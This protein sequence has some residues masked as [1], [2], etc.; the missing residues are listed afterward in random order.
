MCIKIEKNYLSLNKRFGCL[1]FANTQYQCCL[2]WNYPWLRVKRVLCYY[3]GHFFWWE[4][5]SKSKT[6]K[7]SYQYTFSKQNYTSKIIKSTPFWSKHILICSYIHYWLR[8]EAAEKEL[9][10][11]TK[12]MREKD[13]LK[14]TVR[15]YRF[16]LL[17]I[18][19]PDGVIL[20]GISCPP[21]WLFY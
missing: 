12:K 9:Q 14:M 6:M 1:L 10:L 5:V 4:Y 3:I 13:E 19:F 8:S 15:H 21:S 17:R 11:R 18:R 20:Q 16:V 7:I 2:L